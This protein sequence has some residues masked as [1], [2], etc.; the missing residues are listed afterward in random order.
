[1][2]YNH[3][4]ILF[5]VFCLKGSDKTEIIVLNL[6]KDKEVQWFG[7]ALK[8]MENLKMLVIEKARFSSAPNHLPK[9]LI[10]LKWRDYPE[11]SLPVHYNPKKLV[12]LDLSDSIGLFTFGDQMIMVLIF[13]LMCEF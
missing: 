12:I 9:N 4:C 2:L 13:C 5:C 7:N 3:W 1:M 6:L 11:S 10:V 8:N